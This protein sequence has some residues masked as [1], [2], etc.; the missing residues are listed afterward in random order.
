MKKILEKLKKLFPN[1]CVSIRLEN[2][3]FPKTKTEYKQYVLYIED[4][5][6]LV[7]KNTLKE[8]DEY[9]NDIKIDENE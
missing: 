7:T 1:K 4:V 5:C 9:I 3:Y 2:N 8:I 6:C